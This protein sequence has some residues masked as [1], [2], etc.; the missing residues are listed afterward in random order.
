MRGSRVG[1]IIDLILRPLE[2]DVA[3]DASTGWIAARK[4]AS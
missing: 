4:K 3:A 1:P 2:N